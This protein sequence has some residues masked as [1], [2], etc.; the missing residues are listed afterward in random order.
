VVAGGGEEAGQL[1]VGPCPGDRAACASGAEVRL[2]GDVLPEELASHGEVERGADDHVDLADGLW[3]EAGSMPTARG[4]EAGV[5]GFEVVEA[6]AAQRDV[7]EGRVDVAA[8]E[9]GVAVGGGL[10]DLPSLA[11]QPR[12][13][14]EPADGD[15]TAQ[16]RRRHLPLCI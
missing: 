15:G 9:P 7:A 1:G 5:E 6:E 4:G 2:V 12:V 14:E 16:P 10:A 3:G 8:D 11:G 13:G